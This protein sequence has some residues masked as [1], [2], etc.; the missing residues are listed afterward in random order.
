M[1]CFVW[2]QFTNINTLVEC[3]QSAGV[4]C[5]GKI[6]FWVDPDGT[7]IEEGMKLSKG[8]IWSRVWF[9]HVYGI[10]LHFA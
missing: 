1:T 8:N 4:Q 9:V 10:H 6:H 5:A 2:L 7:Y 3:L